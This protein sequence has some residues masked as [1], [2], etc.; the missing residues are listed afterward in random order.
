VKRPLLILIAVFACYVL[1]AGGH[2]YSPDEEILYRTTRALATRASPAIEPLQGFATR[3]ADPPRAD[4]LEYAQYGIGQPLLA[5]PLYWIG[6]LAGD[7]HDN[8]AA[9]T[10]FALSWFNI[11]LGPWLAL[12]VYLIALELGANAR[13]ATLTAF[14]YAL[15][16]LAWPH[17]RPFFTES[18]AALFIMLAWWCLLRGFRSRLSAWCLA[19]GAAAGYAALVRLDSV[20]AYPALAI[21]IVGPLRRAAR[22]QLVSF[23]TAWLAFALPAAVCGTLILCLNKAHFGSCLAS[24]YSDQPE[25]LAFS[26]P[27]VPG[28]YGLLFSAG[29]GLFFFS[30]VLVLSFC[31]WRP[32]VQVLRE[33]PSPAIGA[34][35]WTVWSALLTAILVP[36]LVHAKWPNWSG[37]W[38][39]GPRHVFL[40]H[41]F[42]A[43][44]IAAWLTVCWNGA[45][46]VTLAVAFIVGI[47]V[48]LLGASQ[49]FILFHQ[50]FFRLDETRSPYFV[51]YDAYDAQY[52]G[53]YYRVLIR[54]DATG[55]WRPFDL[56]AI[57]APIQSSIFMPQH[58][59]WAG[60][61]VMLREGEID[62]YWINRL[63]DLA[64]NLPSPTAI[65]IEDR[66][67]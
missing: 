43:L 36:L 54:D 45:I 40:I 29:K 67:P 42:L 11:L 32:L 38:C 27:L 49:D 28:L 12:F 52:W 33:A 41:A 64:A 61:P 34:R 7:S 30:P 58:S 8:Q 1:T 14:L 63:R 19:A 22:R 4:G 5:V 60:Y 48:Q 55:E 57:P 2:L 56:R 47:G 17:S 21:L 25:G 53:H 24:G 26:S 20:F 44:P 62:N 9:P 59:V 37:G 65:R 15:G 66:T 39:W 35:I 31:G 13:A 50:R 51:P 6:T 16:S 46:R 3:P 23:W 18:C 10:R